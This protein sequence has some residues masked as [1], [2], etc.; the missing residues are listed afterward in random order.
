M[1]KKK[2]EKLKEEVR[3]A[4]KDNRRRT[5]HTLMAKYNNLLVS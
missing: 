5:V 2:E 4:V 1:R 3:N